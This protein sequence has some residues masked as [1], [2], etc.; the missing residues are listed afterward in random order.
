MNN[1]Y[2][3]ESIRTLDGLLFEPKGGKRGEFRRIGHAEA[4]VKLIGDDDS[5]LLNAEMICSE[6][7]QSFRAVMDE[8]S[9]YIYTFSIV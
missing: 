9:G 2:L 4:L 1:K 8:W 6:H 7:F 5:L 3:G